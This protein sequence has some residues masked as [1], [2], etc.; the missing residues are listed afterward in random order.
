ME[1]GIKMTQEEKARR[2]DEAVKEASIACKD[3]DKHLKATLERIF[4]ELNE[5]EDERIRKAIYNALKYL[6]R[7]LSW[8]F[9]DDID[10]LDVY[11][12]L[13]KQGKSALEAINEEKVDNQNCVK[14]TDK[15]E[16]KFHEGE[17][18]IDKEDGT[19]FF[20]KRV[21]G[22]TYKYITNTGHEY[23]CTHYSLENDARLWTIFDAKDGD[24]LVCDINKAEIGGDVEE[25]P[26][27]VPTILIFKKV[28]S[29]GYIHS[30]CH[31]YGRCFLGLQ[32]TMYYDSFVFNIHPATKEQ[33]DALKRATADAG[34]T[35]DFEKKELKKI[36]NIVCSEKDEHWRC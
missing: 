22:N 20:I 12:W 27:I 10:I 31:L 1:G 30:Y 4:P 35:F 17:W 15:V 5:S 13:E 23:S 11:D 3:E 24:I 34:Y 28:T 18:C 25:L 32:N 16:P 9:L 2:Y 21:L 19:I 7:E 36:E 29:R 26:N 8:D 6:E 14:P 33:R